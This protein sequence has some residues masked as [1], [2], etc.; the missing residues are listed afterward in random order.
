MFEV[1]SFMIGRFCLLEIFHA[2]L[3]TI[4]D[5]E[6]IQGCLNRDLGGMEGLMG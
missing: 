2:K 5:I 3:G 1:G 6:G 4:R